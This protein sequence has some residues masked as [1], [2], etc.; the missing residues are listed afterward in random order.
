M[1]GLEED[2]DCLY[3]PNPY[4]CPPRPPDALNLALLNHH[5]SRISDILEGL[6]NIFS[7]YQYVVSWKNPLLTGFTF[8]V[9]VSFCSR[10]NAE[11]SITALSYPL[12]VISK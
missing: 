8:L 6:G 10:F 5:I 1:A 9:F 3:G 11:V 4:E 7:M 12:T 2:V